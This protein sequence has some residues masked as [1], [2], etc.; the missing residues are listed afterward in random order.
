MDEQVL[1]L[2]SKRDAA[3]TCEFLS[4]AGIATRA[5]ANA[6]ELYR[7][8]NNGAGALIVAGELL[9]EDRLAHLSEML[10]HQPPWSDIPI[11]VVT[12]TDMATNRLAQLNET[13]GTVSLL[14]RPL[15]IDTLISTVRAAVRA[16]RR[17]YQLRDLLKQREE[18][19]RR[20][21]EF[22]AMLAHELRNPLAPIRM[23]LQILRL[24][25]SR[26]RADQTQTM[27][28]RQVTNLSRL[29]DDLLDVSRITRGNIMLKKKPLSIPEVLEQ[30]ADSHQRLAA[31]K[32]IQLHLD[33]PREPLLVD[34][35][36]TRMEQMIGNILAN[37]IKFTP[38]KGEIRLSA[39]REVS[40]AVVR[41]K[42]SG[43]G[44]PPHMLKQVFELFTQTDRP[45]DRAQ[46]GLGIGLTVT[47]SLAEMHGGTIE[48]LSEGE[49]T[50]T[51]FVLRFPALSHAES[52]PH[53]RSGQA[54]TDGRTP[55][56]VLVVED[57]RDAADALAAYLRA[58]GHEVHVAYDGRAGMRAALR[59]QPDVVIC[60]IGLPELD[61]YELAKSLR[62]EPDLSR[63]L[64]VAVTGYGDARDRSRGLEAG[65]QHYLTKPADPELL[66]R[67]VSSIE[68][69]D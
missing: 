32:G 20:R 1:V 50:G 53:A 11:I 17:Q 14:H 69:D 64:L 12:S 56:C 35:D 40:E 29:I 30:V 13:L 46:G 3:L 39:A 28:E 62:A 59:E 47:R 8:I 7:E 61:G 36:P 9:A 25:D 58:N 4:E 60:D 22:L 24:A 33:L 66:V 44:I 65:F 55:R 43:I 49:G 21:E 34:A 10:S 54:Q 51:E 63:T 27:I 15:S 18:A 23:G 45:L 5:C 37:A 2:A 67:I 16:R 31:E 48:A 6:D 41:V 19:E 38:A 42:D 26:D 52:A 57:N 68:R